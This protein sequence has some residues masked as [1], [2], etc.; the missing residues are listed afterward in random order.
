MK[1][2]QVQADLATEHRQQD[3]AD[4][5][6]CLNEPYFADGGGNEEAQPV[7]WGDQPECK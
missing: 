3:D 2:V 6:E 5:S 4:V 7:G 1:Q